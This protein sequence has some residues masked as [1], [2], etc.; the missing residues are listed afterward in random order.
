MLD[1]L[2]VSEYESCALSMIRITVKDD[3]KIKKT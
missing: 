3:I 1:N 2:D